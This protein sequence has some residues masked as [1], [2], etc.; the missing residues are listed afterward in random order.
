ME[1]HNQPTPIHRRN[2][3]S[4]EKIAAVRENVREIPRSISR[5]TRSRFFDL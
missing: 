4:A 1:G 5:R 2:T 3:K